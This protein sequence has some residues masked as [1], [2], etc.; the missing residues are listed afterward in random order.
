MKFKFN[1]IFSDCNSIKEFQD[2]MAP[3][4]EFMISKSTDGFHLVEKK[5]YNQT[6]IIY[7]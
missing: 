5:I 3:L 4:V 6:N 1:H 2:N 7:W